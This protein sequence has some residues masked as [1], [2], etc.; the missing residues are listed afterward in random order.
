MKY[1]LDAMLIL[2]LSALSVFSSVKH[3]QLMMP[4]TSLILILFFLNE[5]KCN[6]NMIKSSNNIF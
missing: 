3:R 4:Q 2:T 1:D 6:T 5:K